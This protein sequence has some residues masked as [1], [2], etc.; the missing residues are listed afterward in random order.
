MST[1][2]TL[3]Q[4]Y[5]DGDAI[6]QVRIPNSSTR[7]EVHAAIGSAPCDLIYFD[8]QHGPCT[9]WDVARICSAAEELAVPS[10]LR[11]K[12]QRQAYLI[13]GLLDLGVFAIKVPEVEDEATV[14]EALDSFYFPPVGR[15]SWGG[16]VG[17]GKKGWEG[18][19]REY[20]DWWN[21]NGI[22]GFKIESVKAVLSI[23]ALVKPGI[24]Y[25]DF[26]PSDLR[27]D[28]EVQQHPWL[29]T[30]EDCRAFVERE[31]EGAD[32]RVM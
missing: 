23:R 29:R 18:T 6:A 12:H 22:L 26:G 32:A 15:R 27:F 8:A 3:K 5:H 20:A 9:D 16:N 31:L 4:R 30:V 7:E 11:I 21:Q 28:L 19:D 10:L 24:D 13:G 2:K 17:Y 14:D 25:V 1:T